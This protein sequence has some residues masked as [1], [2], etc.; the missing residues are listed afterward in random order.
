MASARVRRAHQVLGA[1]HP[2]D[3]VGRE[4]LAIRGHLR[5]AGYESEVFAGFV[6]PRLGPEARPLRD[7]PAR[8]GADAACLYHFSPG[9]PAG[10]VALQ[11]RGPLGVVYHN[12][13]PVRFFAGWSDESARLAA[14][15]DG[16]LRELARRASL[17]LA[18][19]A[20]SRRDLEAAG[21]AESSVLPFVHDPGPPPARSPVFERLYAD[22]RRHVLAVGRLA[23]NKRLEDVLR[24]FALLQRG[25]IPR[26]RLLL[27]GEEGLRTYADA[28][29]D[30]AR[31]LRLRDV[32]F[33][34][35]VEEG[36]LRSA[37]ALAD[38]L[39]SLS[40]HE[41]Y[42][43]P[44]VEAMLAG[45]PVVAYDA[46]AVAETM[47]GAGVLLRDKSPEL[48]A[49]VVERLLVDD[50]L[51]AA[52]LARQEAVAARIR[53]T[54]FQALVLGALARVLEAQP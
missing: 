5:A 26:S 11:A 25:P 34:G 20:F 21:F 39:L 45:V 7:H 42:G 51:R 12:V 32:V 37:Y 53:S 2:G 19:S 48:V 33:C 16:E 23:P 3:A 10:Q 47:A 38:V 6:D 15:A 31:A 35:R 43:V 50:S 13:T 1:L 18:K 28:L 36:E 14:R 52:V 41:G 54:D 49:G 22:G 44:L 40:E 8:D 4:A 46:G 27:V 9:S 17:G 24:A 29:R 30:L